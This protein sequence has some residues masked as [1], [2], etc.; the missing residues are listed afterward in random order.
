MSLSLGGTVFAAQDK[1]I[2]PDAIIKPKLITQMFL[3][4]LTLRGS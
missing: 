4:C 2:Y 1:S 3:L